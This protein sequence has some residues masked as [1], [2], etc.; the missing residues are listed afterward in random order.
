VGSSNSPRRS[1]PG[2]KGI[3][4]VAFGLLPM[5]GKIKR[6]LPM[7]GKKRLETG[8]APHEAEAPQAT[9]PKDP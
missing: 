4:A 8:A 3:L 6:N 9:G 5:F 1:R 7:F 2:G